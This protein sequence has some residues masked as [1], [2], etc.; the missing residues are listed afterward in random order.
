MQRKVPPV[1]MFWRSRNFHYHSPN[2]HQME[3]R[4]S[5]PVIWLLVVCMKLTQWSKVV[6]ELFHIGSIEHFRRVNKWSKRV[7]SLATSPI[8]LIYQTHKDCCLWISRSAAIKKQNQRILVPQNV[9]Q[10]FCFVVWSM[11]SVFYPSTT[12]RCNRWGEKRNCWSF[13]LDETDWCKSRS[14]TNF[15]Q[16]RKTFSSFSSFF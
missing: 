6:N 4:T 9:F 2:S 14:V 11:V 10:F 16:H 12:D 5:M 13:C 15:I 8:D 1:F 7:F 3:L